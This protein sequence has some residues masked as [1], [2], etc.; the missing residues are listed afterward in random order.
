[1]L[2]SFAEILP[3]PGSGGSPIGAFTCYGLET[4]AGVIHAA[5]QRGRPVMLLISAKAY[6]SELGRPLLR[7]LLSLG[8]A[9]AGP[10]A[11]QLDHVS[12]LGL[13]EEALTDGVQAIMADGSTLGYRANLDLVSAARKLAERHG[14]GVEAELGHLAGDEEVAVGVTS[15]GYTDPVEAAAFAS[16]SG[17]SCLA[18]SIGNVHGRYAE[19][20][21]LDIPLL[22]EIEARTDL[23]LS[24][25]GAS[26]LPDDQIQDALGGAIAKININTELRE[27]YVSV[28]DGCLP[29]V[30]RGLDLLT[31][32]SRLVSETA[33]LVGEKLDALARMAVKGAA[34]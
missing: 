27:R 7:T 19:P 4:A 14:A 24:L 21:R 10:V 9:A 5:E 2:A 11:V 32:G 13:I 15:H 12:D 33:E 6:R 3:A 28:L 25:H 8:E 17:A 31:L 29:D 18:I 23:P 20:P 26:G 16:A 1:M 22:R 34:P 30:R